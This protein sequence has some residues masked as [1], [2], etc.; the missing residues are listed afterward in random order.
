MDE[1]YH[2]EWENMALE[3][4]DELIDRLFEVGVRGMTDDGRARTEDW[5]DMALQEPDEMRRILEGSG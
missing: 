4:L 3:Y 2:E 1:D 5:E